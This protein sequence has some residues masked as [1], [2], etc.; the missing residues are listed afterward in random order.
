[1]DGLIGSDK[2]NVNKAIFRNEQ[3]K[4]VRN[5]LLLNAGFYNISAI[6]ASPNLLTR[7]LVD[8]LSPTLTTI[9][10]KHII[11]GDVNC[12]TNLIPRMTTNIRRRVFEFL[13]DNTL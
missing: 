3:V 4:E 6:Y 2:P 13:N 7:S 10:R 1:M 9:N 12:R 8:G 5:K 11:L